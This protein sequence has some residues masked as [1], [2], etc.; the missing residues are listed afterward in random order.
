LWRRKRTAANKNANDSV[1]VYASVNS[2]ETFEKG[3]TSKPE[4]EGKLTPQISNSA[5][6]IMRR[7]IFKEP[8]FYIQLYLTNYYIS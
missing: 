4:S 1:I 2:V 7:F 5:N 6:K 8:V 3:I